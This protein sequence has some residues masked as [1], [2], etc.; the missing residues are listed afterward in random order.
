MK[1]DLT[2]GPGVEYLDFW[3]L[4]VRDN[5]RL[6]GFL[7]EWRLN[8]GASIQGGGYKTSFRAIAVR[9]IGTSI[10]ILMML[11]EHRK[12]RYTASGWDDWNFEVR[13]SREIYF[14]W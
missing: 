13:E 10:L 14:S 6:R 9:E 11:H 1:D 4:S 8:P 7:R 3:R 5:R 12:R 2:A